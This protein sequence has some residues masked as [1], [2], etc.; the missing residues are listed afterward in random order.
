MF[1]MACIYCF[2]TLKIFKTMNYIGNKSADF[3]LQSITASEN[4]KHKMDCICLLVSWPCDS[5]SSRTSPIILHQGGNQPKQLTQ[6]VNQNYS[7]HCLFYKTMF[8]FWWI[9]W[10][11]SRMGWFF[12]FYQLYQSI[13][14]NNMH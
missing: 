9:K 4:Q 14:F 1:A 6:S 7:N 11:A 5:F 2:C 10:V 13:R 12:F 3:T 8:C